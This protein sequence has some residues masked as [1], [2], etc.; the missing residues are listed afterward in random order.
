MRYG[1]G[2]EIGYDAKPHIGTDR[3]KGVI[4]ALT[5]G[6]QSLGGRVLFGAKLTGI[7]EAG[8]EIAS[9]SFQW[10]GQTET[11]QPGAVVLA[12]GHSARDTYRM[13]HSLG[14]PLMPCLLYTSRCV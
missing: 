1:A 14:V 3:L 6:I 4:S 8:G 11:L 7:L 13:L 9:L 2:E 5:D 10:T 12:T